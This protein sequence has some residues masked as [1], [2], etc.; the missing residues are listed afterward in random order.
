MWGPSAVI[1]ILFPCQVVQND[2]RTT[3][4]GIDS[5][6]EEKPFKQWIKIDL[7]TRNLK[8]RYR[9]SESPHSFCFNVIPRYK[10]YPGFIKKKLF[11]PVGDVL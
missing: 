4:V 5:A 3:R 7:K 8:I 11:L 9:Q 10:N 6:R 2:I 1:V